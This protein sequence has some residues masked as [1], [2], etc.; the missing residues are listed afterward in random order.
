MYKTSQQYLAYE[1]HSVNINPSFIVTLPKF[2][3]HMQKLQTTSF[4]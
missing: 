3:L 2:T 1:A 4:D